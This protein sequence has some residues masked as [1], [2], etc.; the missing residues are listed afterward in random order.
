[1]I[2]GKTLQRKQNFV[3]ITQTLLEEAFIRNLIVRLQE[4]VLGLALTEF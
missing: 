2:E 3:K 4:I 1:M